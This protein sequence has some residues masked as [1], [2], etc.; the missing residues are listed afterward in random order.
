M[1]RTANW[2]I[3]GYWSTL[4]GYLLCVKATQIFLNHYTIVGV[5]YMGMVPKVI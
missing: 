2:C 1:D 5:G 4:P 3:G